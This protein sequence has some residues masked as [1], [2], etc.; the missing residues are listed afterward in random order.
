MTEPQPSQ[1]DINWS[2]SERPTL[3][4]IAAGMA[5]IFGYVGGLQV[6]AHFLQPG[7]IPFIPI[8]DLP[9]TIWY[10]VQHYGAILPGAWGFLPVTAA[11]VAAAGAF[12]LTWIATTRDN[13]RHLRGVRL[14][15]NPKVVARALR[16]ARG[17]APGIALHP[18]IRISEHQECRHVLILGGAGSGKTTILWPLIRGIAE[19]GDRCLI[20]DFK[21][22]FT[23]SLTGQLTLLAPADARSARWVVGRDISTRLEAEAL[24]ETLIPLPAGGGDAIWAR[25]ARGLLIGLIAHLQST[26]PNA[27]DFADLARIASQTLVNYKLLCEI[28]EREHP[29]ARAFLMGRDSKTTASFLAELSGALSHVINLGVASAAANPKAGTWSVRGWLRDGS[30][31]PRAVMLGY[32]PSSKELSQAFLASIIEQVVR[33]VASM[34]DCK[35]DARRLWLVLDEVPQ[36]G[37]IPSISAALVTLRSKGVR[38]VLGLQSIAQIEQV[39]DRHTATIWSSSTATKIICSI[40][41]P[42]DQRW[43]SDL[44]GDREVERFHGQTQIAPGAGATSRSSSWHRVREPVMLPAQFGQDLGINKKGPR[45]VLLGGGTAAMLDWPFPEVRRIRKDRID[46]PWVKVGYA[47][48]KWGAVPPPV[49]VPPGDDESVP[50]TPTSTTNKKPQ[51]QVTRSEYVR[52]AIADLNSRG[53]MPPGTPR[54]ALVR[55]AVAAAKAQEKEQE[56][57]DPVGDVTGSALLDAALPGAGVIGDLARQMLDAAGLGDDATEQVIV[58]EF[59]AGASSESRDDAAIEPDNELE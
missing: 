9:S 59:P 17:E 1:S 10:V 16:P 56:S 18:G 40:Q 38:V 19:R 39:Y 22:D 8:R 6:D 13:E 27:W 12:M 57:P 3:S 21:G 43:A 24:A 45:A 41:S 11:G 28:V 14:H 31:F 4:F 32:R 29:P 15:R 5:G 26:K 25:G 58:Q 52:R 44:L 46:A 20:F 48:P 2:T 34:S 49:A 42:Q 47:R 37:R 30:K 55:T 23:A 36:C 50:A 33:Q 35:P 53:G 7:P 54:S 51:E